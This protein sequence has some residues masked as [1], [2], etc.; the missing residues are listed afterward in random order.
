MNTHRCWRTK[1]V[2]MAKCFAATSKSW[3]VQC[4]DSRLINRVCLGLRSESFTWKIFKL[5][6]FY[7]SVSANQNKIKWTRWKSSK[8]YSTMDLQ[9]ESWHSVI[10]GMQIDTGKM[11]ATTL[12]AM[13]MHIFT[14]CMF[15]SFNSWLQFFHSKSSWNAY[16]THIYSST[17]C[18]TTNQFTEI[19]LTKQKKINKFYISKFIVGSL[20]KLTVRSRIE[21]KRRKKENAD[22]KCMQSWLKLPQENWWNR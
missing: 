5:S 18:E 3:C 10:N 1:F 8:V 14:L 22:A 9:N 17:P 11:R 20:A 7:F 4:V 13:C 6:F 2:N 12:T 15:K 21:M 19:A 16:H